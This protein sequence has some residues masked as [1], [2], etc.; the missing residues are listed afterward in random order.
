MAVGKP[1]LSSSVADA[2]QLVRHGETGFL[3]SSGDATGLRAALG[4]AFA[5]REELKSMGERARC[6]VESAHSWAARCRAIVSAAN[7]L[8]LELR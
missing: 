6:L 8:A 7:H 2:R 1:V 3:F 4:R 5:A